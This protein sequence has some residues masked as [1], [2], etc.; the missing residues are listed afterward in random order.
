MLWGPML[1]VAEWMVDLYVLG[2]D[3]MKAER[4]AG[5]PCVTEECADG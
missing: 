5:S 3:W 1:G 2:R 4:S